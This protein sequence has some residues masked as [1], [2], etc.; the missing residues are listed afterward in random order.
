[1]CGRPTSPFV[2]IG[3]EAIGPKCAQRAGLTPTRVP[4]GSR[5]RF[6]REKPVRDDEPTTGDLFEG[7]T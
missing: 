1:M 7:L 3:R 5:L 6:V 4:K 2:M